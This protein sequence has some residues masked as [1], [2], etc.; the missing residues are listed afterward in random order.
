MTTPEKRELLR[1][2]ILRV[3]E[4]NTSRFGLGITA[5]IHMLGAYGTVGAPDDVRFEVYYLH[6]KGFLT[7]VDKA[8]S[9]ENQCW[10]ITAEGRDWVAAH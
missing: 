10:R 5:L 9:P 2:A 6:D 8:I 1:I 3:L 4:A 7:P